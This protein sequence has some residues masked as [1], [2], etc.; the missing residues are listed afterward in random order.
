[1]E[2]TTV[3]KRIIVALDVPDRFAADRLLKKLGDAV[4]YV[5][6]GMELFYAEGPAIITFLKE[7]GYD[8]FLDL[9]C[10]D[11][12]HT[13]RGA[14]K[15]ITT[16]GVDM[17]NV[18]V[19]GGFPMMEAAAEGIEAGTLAGR[20]RPILIG[21]TQLTSMSQE[22]MNRELG[23]PG[24]VE[25]TVVHY[26]RLAKQAGL[27]GVVASPLE[28]ETIKAECGDDFYTVTPG[29]RPKGTQKEDQTR[30]TTPEE[31]FALGSDY[32]VMGRSIT[33]ADDPRKALEDV[34][35][36]VEGSAMLVEK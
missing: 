33:Q 5:K 8:V 23:I 24:T 4:A 21:V 2:E 12:P 28:V 19:A 30:V 36:T 7:R 25:E 20:S 32:I 26:A 22:M 10:H 18:H 29:I 13:V 11:I 14:M 34:V 27:N 31:A 17:V 35:Q 15:S 16:S 3:G 9:K 1:M 6:V